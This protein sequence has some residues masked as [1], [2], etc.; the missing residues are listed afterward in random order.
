MH[1]VVG[2][3]TAASSYCGRVMGP[4]D[5]AQLHHGCYGSYGCWEGCRQGCGCVLCRVTR[6]CSCRV[7][8]VC[9]C[10]YVVQ[11]L[12]VCMW[13]PC[14]SRAGCVACLHRVVWFASSRVCDV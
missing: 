2:G 6:P 13:R 3:H 4:C 10:V 12:V 7:C 1:A 11:L 5:A 9:V 8:R 14:D